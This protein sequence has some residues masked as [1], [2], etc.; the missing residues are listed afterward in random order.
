VIS[1]DPEVQ[2]AYE[3]MVAAGESHSIAELLALR[4]FPG[5][6]G[7]DAV[8]MEGRKLDGSQFQGQ[9][10]VAS[11]HLKKAR[12]AGVNP[13]GKHYLG[14]LADHPGDPRA[15]VSGLGDVRRVCEERGWSC[16]GAVKVDAPKYADG[17]VPPDRYAPAD[18]LVEAEVR[19]R[20]ADD[21]ARANFRGELK[22]E[23]ARE[24]AGVHGE[25]G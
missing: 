9:D 16:D 7:T 11:H 3:A 1:D 23:V 4:T 20:I 8:F 2:S 17:Y 18:D 25:G 19:A 15:W 14:G 21:P 22:H 5:I 13:V 24:M 12:D 10:L 6:K